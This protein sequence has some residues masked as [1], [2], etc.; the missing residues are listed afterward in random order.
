MQIKWLEDFKELAKTR[1]F[2]RA[3]HN[4]NVTH[5]AFGRRIKALEAWVGTALVERSEH[6]VTLTPAGRLFLDAAANAVD[7]L[8]DARL[9]LREAQLPVA[10]KIGTGRTLARTCVPGWFEALARQR[11]VF[12]LSVTTGGTQEGVLA[13]AD[14]TVDLLIADASP[15]AEAL[16][17]P[18]KYDACRLGSETLVP[19]S[20][21][22]KRGRPRFTLPGTAAAPLPWLAF[23]RGLTLR[24]MLDAH[25]AAADR[26]AYLQPVFQADFYE[27]VEE[28]ALRGFGMAWLPHRLAKPHL[29]VGAL[30]P[31]G[32]DG[33]QI[34][35]DISMVRVRSNQNAL[36]DEVWQLAVANAQT[37]AA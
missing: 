34:H 22:D 29:H 1:S 15:Q 13:L 27:A 36:L 9:L 12:P 5:P 16:L 23:A 30:R 32:G 11:G 33:W 24:Q 37:P 31:A 6:P 28:M 26:K 8:N 35:V 2:S 21:P 3:A 20:A 14:G 19:V 4:R 18:R 25:L 17:D 7:G 10:L